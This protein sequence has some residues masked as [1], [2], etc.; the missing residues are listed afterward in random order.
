MGLKVRAV[1]DDDASSVL[2]ANSDNVLPAKLI[3][4]RF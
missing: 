4:R 1:T 3:Y 2:S